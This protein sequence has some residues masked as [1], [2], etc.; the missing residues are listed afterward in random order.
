MAGVAP[1]LIRKVFGLF[2]VTGRTDTGRWEC[3]CKCGVVRIKTTWEIAK[4][5]QTGRKTSCWKCAAVADLIG[6]RFGRL[7]VV[8]LDRDAANQ[9]IWLCQCD[10]GGKIHR[11]TGH[12]TQIKAPGCRTCTAERRAL[13]H[14]THGASSRKKFSKDRRL[15]K[16]WAGMI[17]RCRNK[18][19]KYYGG[20]GIEVCSE[21]LSFDGFRSWAKENGYADNLTIER[22][23]PRLNYEPANC[24]WI[25]FAENRRRMHE[26]HR[27]RPWLTGDIF[28]AQHYLPIEA[29]FGTA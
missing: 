11:R 15:Y 2:T 19:D 24:E 25:T 21:W 26:S 10:C 3:T 9:P 13:A 12:L 7:V 18:S 29:L 14:T 28:S 1:D 16:V 20:K 8:R 23:N 4:A 6:L 5:E 22:K 17:K 27:G